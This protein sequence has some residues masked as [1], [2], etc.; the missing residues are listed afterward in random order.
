MSREGGAFHFINEPVDSLS[1]EQFY[2]D[3]LILTS[4][5]QDDRD[6]KAKRPGFQFNFQK[7]AHPASSNR[8]EPASDEGKSTCVFKIRHSCSN[9]ETRAR[10]AAPRPLLQR[11][12]P[13][14]CTP[15]LRFT[16]ISVTGAGRSNPWLCFARRHFTRT[17]PACTPR[18]D[19]AGSRF[20]F[21]LPRQRHDLPSH[22]TARARSRHPDRPR[23]NPIPASG[24]D[25][26][27][28]R[29]HGDDHRKSAEHDHRAG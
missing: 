19:R 8:T 5:N 17:T 13:T 3:F 6:A 20:V 16:D 28:C 14:L 25:A 18:R 2:T 22:D 10:Y 24:R 4:E 27:K 9:Q 29:Q 21:S 1:S 15:I 26:F 11:L 12:S 23:S 7:D